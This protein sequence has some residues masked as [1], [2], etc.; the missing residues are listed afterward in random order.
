MAKQLG[1]LPDH[2]PTTDTLGRRTGP[3]PGVIEGGCR[4]RPPR[5]SVC[6]TATRARSC[7]LKLPLTGITD[8]VRLH[9]LVCPAHRLCRRSFSNS[10]STPCRS[11][12]PL[13]L[14][15]HLLQIRSR[16]FHR[17]S[18]ILDVQITCQERTWRCGRYGSK[19]NQYSRRV[20]GCDGSLRNAQVLKDG[21]SSF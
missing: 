1:R 6:R 2:E 21:V 7:Q 12:S 15:Q 17:V 20:A 16:P 11:F 19:I 3:F 4:R 9:P 10:H 14:R 8:S 13:Y 5:R 18:S